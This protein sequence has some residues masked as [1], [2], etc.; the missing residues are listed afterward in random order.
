MHRKRMEARKSV[1]L[2]LRLSAGEGRLWRGLRHDLTDSAFSF[3][4]IK[5]LGNAVIGKVSVRIEMRSLPS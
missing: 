2:G 3:D 1:A 4:R 5:C